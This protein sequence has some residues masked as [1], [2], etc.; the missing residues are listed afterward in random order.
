MISPEVFRS[1]GVLPSGP[2]SAWPQERNNNLLEAQAEKKSSRLAKKVKA[3][4]GQMTR[5]AIRN[6]QQATVNGLVSKKVREARY[7]TC[8]SCPFF[9]KES[10]RCSECGC[11]MEAKSWI[12]GDPDVLCP[13]KLWSA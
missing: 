8:K 2:V 10:K 4:A 3:T 11:F 6:A 13:K 5:G 1:A 9:I 7:D 12:N